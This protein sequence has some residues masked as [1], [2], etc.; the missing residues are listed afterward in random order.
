M[1]KLFLNRI[2]ALC[3]VFLFTIPNLSVLAKTT[4][5]AEKSGFSYTPEDAK[6][7]K[8]EKTYEFTQKDEEIG[9][10]LW[11]KV[12]S[13]KLKK[14]KSHI[15]VKV[16][17][18]YSNI[19]M[20]HNLE[21]AQNFK[22]DKTHLFKE[23]ELKYPIAWDDKEYYGMVMVPSDKNVKIS[24]SSE[25]NAPKTF[26][27]EIDISDACPAEQL[28]ASSKDIKNIIPSLK[29]IRDNML[30]SSSIGKDFIKLYYTVS[31][32]LTVSILKDKN[33]RNTLLKEAKNLT[34]FLK[35]VSNANVSGKTEYIVSKLNIDSLKNI[36]DAIGKNLDKESKEK[37]EK[38]WKDLNVESYENKQLATFI[39]D[40]FLGS[41]EI[42]TGSNLIIKTSTSVKIDAIKNLVNSELKNQGL[43]NI[44]DIKEEK[45]L[46]DKNKKVFLINIPYVKDTTNIK[47]AIK[48]SSI[49]NYIDENYLVEKTSNDINYKYNW[50]M[51]NTGQEM[52]IYDDSNKTN[53]NAGV[54]INYKGIEEVLSKADVKKVPIAV[55]DTG[56][57]YELADFKDVVDMNKAKDICFDGR[58]NVMDGVISHGTHVSGIIAAKA[59]N[60][61]STSGINQNSSIIPIRLLNGLGQGNIYD[62]A[63]GIKYAVDNGAKVINLSLGIPPT[64][65]PEVMNPENYPAI[66]EALKYAYDK[67]V[68]VV[69]AAGNEFEEGMRYPATSK[70]T[71]A[72][73]ATNNKD[74]RAEF[75]SYGKEIDVVAPGESILSLV[76]TG[77]SEYMSGTSMA[78]PV[79]SA[80]VG[81]MYSVNSD[82]T[83]DN[84][85]KILHETSVDLGEKGFDKEYGYGR[86]DGKKAV[87]AAIK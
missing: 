1:K 20:F 5:T 64:G 65:D 16:D 23:N 74:N 51:E 28:S 41:G 80:I 24:I 39:N 42:L 12:D 75:S 76:T 68:T 6:V 33:L 11:F 10:P 55:I 14:D 36:K 77:E 7:I 83:P 38:I 40:K 53:G 86:V 56:I 79:V 60:H 29:G 47:N 49:V 34:P 31:K 73:G 18:E 54:D 19:S 22:T 70:Y 69:A 62:V 71:I 2:S 37:L 26:A 50:M 44:I 17:G 72:V 85:R 32:D 46:F 3:L 35:E 66:E 78:T 30:K 21:S 8:I 9:Y 82:I 25:T 13:E 48:K 43:K 58:G 63:K 81:L 45:D 61:Y 87:E 84:V 67:G 52:P 59:N 4:S 15:V 57:N 27:P